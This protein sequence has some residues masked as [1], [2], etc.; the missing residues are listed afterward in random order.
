MTKN[1]TTNLKKKKDLFFQIDKNLIENKK[2][3]KN[4]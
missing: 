3:V 1:K 4:C 2:Q